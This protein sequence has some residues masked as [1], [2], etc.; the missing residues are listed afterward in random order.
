[1]PAS[2]ENFHPLVSMLTLM[3]SLLH[4]CVDSGLSFDSSHPEGRAFLVISTEQLG[5]HFQ[6]LHGYTQKPKPSNMGDQILAT[7]KVAFSNIS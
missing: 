4:V 1:M 5:N 2:L 6:Q 3:N 7:L